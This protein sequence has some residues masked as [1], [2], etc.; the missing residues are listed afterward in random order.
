M[1]RVRA[2]LA[3]AL[4]GLVVA[5]AY[6]P[7][8]TPARAQAPAAPDGFTLQLN[9]PP[10]TPHDPVVPAAQREIT[11]T[12]GWHPVPGYSGS[13]AIERAVQ[14]WGAT[15]PK[16]WATV[17]TVTEARFVDRFTSAE[18]LDVQRCYRIRTATAP[19]GSPSPATAEACTAIQPPP[20]DSGPANVYLRISGG[21]EGEGA[22]RHATFSVDWLPLDGFEGRFFVERGEAGL[23]PGDRPNGYHVL[24]SVPGTTYIDHLPLPEARVTKYCYHIR[25][26]AYGALGGAAS[27]DICVALAPPIIDNPEPVYNGR[28]CS[29]GVLVNDFLVV[30]EPPQGPR[31]TCLEPQTGSG[32]ERFYRLREVPPGL[33]FDRVER[34]P[35]H[36]VSSVVYVNPDDPYHQPAVTISASRFYGLPDLLIVRDASIVSA[37]N[38]LPAPGVTLDDGAI[39]RSAMW[40]EADGRHVLSIQPRYTDLSLD[41]AIG[42]LEPF[43]P[44]PTQLEPAF[45]NATVRELVVPLNGSDGRQHYV[46][47]SEDTAGTV[48]VRLSL[49]DFPPGTYHAVLF[50]KGSCASAATAGYGPADAYADDSPLQTFTLDERAGLVLTFFNTRAITITPGPYSLFDADGTSL[51]LYRPGDGGAGPVACAELS[52][53]PPGPPDTGSGLAAGGRRGGSFLVVIGMLIATAAAHVTVRAHRR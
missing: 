41:A 29:V 6:A 9:A 8:P 5:F 17:T 4:V 30:Q 51:A 52:G 33:V 39:V 42:L 40:H 28:P 35:A 15:G 13:Y 36:G 19:S 1:A 24:A 20:T 38:D 48:R 26:V 47:L 12:L 7:N 27:A 23:A 11:A 14:L 32:P 45:N 43:T 46:T 21:L 53:A 2:T 37:A 34:D 18:H 16:T 49:F 22:D 44:A 31:P 50:R 3:L 25:P 10:P